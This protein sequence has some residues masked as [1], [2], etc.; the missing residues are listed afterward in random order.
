[1]KSTFPVKKSTKPGQEVNPFSTEITCKNRSFSL[2]MFYIIR[3]YPTN[4]QSFIVASNRD[5]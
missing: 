4:Y 2:C 5:G 3:E 1:M